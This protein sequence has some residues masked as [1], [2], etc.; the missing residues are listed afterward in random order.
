MNIKIHSIHFD[1]D[2]KLLDFINEKVSK[3]ENFFDRIISTEVYLKLEAKSHQ[4]SD[5]VAEIKL[6]LPGKV[7]FAEG[8]SMV[9][10]ESID[11]ALDSMLRQVKRHKERIQG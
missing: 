1:A 4:V 11:A 6:S 10:E 7:L 3:V 5:K 8:K 9:F 2:Q